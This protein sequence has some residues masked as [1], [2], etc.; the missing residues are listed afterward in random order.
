MN[1]YGEDKLQPDWRGVK[2]KFLI[3]KSTN[4]TCI[5]LNKKTNVS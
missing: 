5:I 4:L 3:I 1:L 2:H